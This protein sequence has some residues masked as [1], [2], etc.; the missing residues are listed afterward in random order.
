MKQLRVFAIAL[1]LLLCLCMCIGCM[2][3]IIPATSET[4]DSGD[5]DAPLEN[6]VPDESDEPSESNEPSESQESTEP[7]EPSNCTHETFEN[8]T[9]D[10]SKFGAC[11]QS[12]E[13]STC[14]CGKVKKIAEHKYS[15][16]LDNCR[17]AL[18]QDYAQ[19]KDDGSYIVSS[20][21]YCIDCGVQYHFDGNST[22]SDNC[23]IYIS[24]TIYIKIGETKILDDLL[25][26]QVVDYHEN[27]TY[28]QVPLIDD[29]PC[30]S[31]YAKEKCE[32]CGE[33]ISE[34][35]IWL[36]INCNL[37]EAPK[38]SEKKTD[39]NGIEHTIEKY[40]CLDCGL[41]YEYDKYIK[42]TS[43]CGSLSSSTLH[44]YNGKDLLFSEQ[45]YLVQN[46]Y[47]DYQREYRQIGESCDAE[48][49][50]VWIDT[51]TKCN[52]QVF[53]GNM[54]HA[55]ENKYFDLSQHSACGGSI[56][57]RLCHF[58]NEG[59]ISNYFPS[60]S[61]GNC[62]S[63]SGVT[64][65][66][67]T[68]KNGNVHNV[69]K[70][71]C[72]NCELHHEIDRWTVQTGK[73]SYISYLK[74]T[75]S[76]SGEVIFEKESYGSAYETHEY[77]VKDQKM[78]GAICADGSDVTYECKVC[79]NS[80]EVY[81]DGCLYEN[82]Y[83]DI[84]CGIYFDRCV[85]CGMQSDVNYKC[86]FEE[87]S[88][89]EFEVET[90][91]EGNELPPPE[92]SPKY[93]CEVCD[94]EWRDETVE[95][96]IGSCEYKTTGSE[97]VLIDGQVVFE[98]VHQGNETYISHYVYM[99]DF[100]LPD[101]SCENGWTVTYSCRNCDE[102]SE[103]DEISYHDSLFYRDYF[104]KYDEYDICRGHFY[105]IQTCPCGEESYLGYDYRDIGEHFC[106]EC[107]IKVITS[108]EFETDDDG[109][110]IVDENYHTGCLIATVYAKADGSD[111]YVELFSVKEKGEF[112]HN[113]DYDV[114][115]E[116][117]L[118]E[119]SAD[120]EDGYTVIVKDFCSTCGYSYTY[121]HDMSGHLRNTVLM[122]DEEI[123][124][125]GICSDHNISF[126]TCDICK[127]LLYV[128][129]T[130]SDS[131]ELEPTPESNYEGYKCINCDL[132]VKIT[133]DDIQCVDENEHTKQ[134]SEHLCIGDE[135]IYCKSY[136]STN[137]HSHN[138]V[139]NISLNDGAESCEDGWT[140][141]C[142]YTCKDCGHQY[143]EVQEQGNDHY[144]VTLFDIKDE[145]FTAYDICE[146]H[147]C[148]IRICLCGEEIL[149]LDIPDEDF[150][151]SDC[152]LIID[153]DRISH[154]NIDSNQHMTTA[155]YTFYCG[156]VELYTNEFTYCEPHK[157]TYQIS[158]RL[159]DGSE[160]C[161]DGWISIYDHTCMHCN[162]SYTTEYEQE[163]LYGEHRHITIYD[164]QKGDSE[165]YGFCDEHQLYIGNCLCGEHH[166]VTYTDQTNTPCTN[167]KFYLTV[168]SEEIVIPE[169]GIHTVTRTYVLCLK[170]DP[171]TIIFTYEYVGRGCSSF[172]FSKKISCG[173]NCETDGWVTKYDCVDGCGESN[174]DESPSYDHSYYTPGFVGLS[175]NGHYEDLDLDMLICSI[176]GDVVIND[177]NLVCEI[178][179][180]GKTYNCTE[181]DCEFRIEVV[182]TYGTPDKYGIA[183]KY[184]TITSWDGELSIIEKTY[185][186]YT[187][188]PN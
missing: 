167:C 121:E 163:S 98:Y 169:N 156:D 135:E 126:T 142:T 69:E 21:G 143:T 97:F 8:T 55:Y 119:G 111:D 96:P 110:N 7:A 145:E 62:Y 3:D 162:Y 22:E 165:K 26:S 59:Y 133:V 88:G 23:T 104:S 38:S 114:E 63:Y 15:E 103:T 89:V 171:D 122:S 33:Y 42:E 65:S 148:E 131:E 34:G 30:G 58:C 144:G 4:T 164:I 184:T 177:S 92:Y 115:P 19:E 43:V 80:Y 87:E 48:L 74:L 120:C 102:Y 41:S 70:I 71:D 36:N 53:G 166:Y 149:F 183:P 29:S 95:T 32:D 9:L 76:K 187:L 77:F 172:M 72:D 125:Y 20:T 79:G 2:P 31:Y 78:H 152:Q 123:A 49:G 84:G 18:I 101:G 112:D 159:L 85:G 5:S 51:C 147:S 81:Y 173:N 155:I 174:F 175:H 1:M 129:Y 185:T 39:E 136:I 178:N 118:N 24:G 44:V 138:C 73:C 61:I 140:Q 139:Y 150:A 146:D 106:D 132:N 57:Y 160:S 113:Y 64:T 116:Y 176:C 168:E 107:S 6:E 37:S 170:D 16:L 124:S 134:I 93:Y 186:S 109:N 181:Q 35:G 14:K 99:S 127:N 75:V 161:L 82:V 28:E 158:Y 108:F 50:Y 10:I 25:L 94:A 130:I 60:F 154:T 40:I 13:I 105:D 128:D 68:D 151:C 11:N 45:E 188:S 67:H 47:H 83:L 66:T 182:I 180:T 117:K 153:I 46:Y 12:I 54:G 157:I 91:E 137:Y 17:V 179:D 27:T 56:E 141:V 86:D 90:D 100:T 52:N